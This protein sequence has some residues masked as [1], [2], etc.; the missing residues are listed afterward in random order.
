MG[1]G[2]WDIGLCKLQ[3]PIPVSHK[4]KRR[5]KFLLSRQWDERRKEGSEEEGHEVEGKE[6]ANLADSKVNFKNEHQN[7][8]LLILF[9]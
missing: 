7:P 2:A 6:S 9:P 8:P 4:T 3:L 1:H 5:L